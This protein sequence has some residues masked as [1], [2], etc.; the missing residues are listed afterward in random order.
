MALPRACT[1]NRVDGAHVQL[2]TTTRSPAILI[3]VG[4]RKINDKYRNMVYPSL[5]AC[6]GVVKFSILTMI[7]DHIH[8]LYAT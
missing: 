3:A 8:E 7:L 4:I 5:F 1:P 2:K 6:E